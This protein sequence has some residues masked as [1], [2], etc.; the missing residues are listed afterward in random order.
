M[1]KLSRVFSLSRLDSAWL[2]L[3]VEE[4]AAKF[5]RFRNVIGYVGNIVHRQNT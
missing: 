1:E 4:G 2:F 5:E 3:S